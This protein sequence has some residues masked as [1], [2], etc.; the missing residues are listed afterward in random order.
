MYTGWSD[1][2]LIESGQDE[3]GHP[4][5][6]FCGST[7]PVPPNIARFTWGYSGTGPQALGAVIIAEMFRTYLG[8]LGARFVE[9]VLSRCPQDQ[10][11]HLTVGQVRQWIEDEQ[12]GKHDK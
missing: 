4:Q 9:D 11:L 12:N 6:F 2:G 3:E 8:Q 5:V 7:L 1:D 10:P